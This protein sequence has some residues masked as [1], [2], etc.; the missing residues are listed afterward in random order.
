ME[1][2]IGVAQINIDG[3]EWPC[4]VIFGPENQYLL[5]ATTLEIFGLMVDPVAG[6]LS[7]QDNQGQ[8]PLESNQSLMAES[9]LIQMVR[10][11]TTN[12]LESAQC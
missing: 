10:G 7:S 11:V 2:E 6:E 4:P 12:K 5:G 8:T 3:T 9:L 1:W